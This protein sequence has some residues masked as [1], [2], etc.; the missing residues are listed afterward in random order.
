[1][2]L[3]YSCLNMGEV[4]DELVKQ[5]EDKADG[6]LIQSVTESQVSSVRRGGRDP[7]GRKA[8]HEGKATGEQRPLES[9]TRRSPGDLHKKV[10]TP[11]AT[12]VPRFLL[13][14]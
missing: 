12:V 7:T 11:S 9:T 5:T 10:L 3:G 6:E 4:R 13:A 14:S 1:M 8:D 2:R